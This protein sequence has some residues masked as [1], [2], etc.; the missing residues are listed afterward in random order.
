MNAKIYH[1][2]RCSKSR[3]TLE[4]LR[5]RGVQPEVVEY[6]KTPPTRDELKSLLAKLGIGARDL[7]RKNEQAFRESGKEL[8]APEDEL[9]DLM[10]ENPILIE[11]PIVVVG[12]RARIG[13]PPESVLDIVE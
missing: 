2:P 4:L 10:V 13:R 3:A 6:L 1:N 11:R 7:I 12:D 5:E 9:I 8:S